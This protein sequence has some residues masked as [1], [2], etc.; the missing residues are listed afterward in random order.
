M[1]TLIFL[2][3]AFAIA[4]VSGWGALGVSEY[5]SFA[6]ADQ[7]D[8]GSYF[9]RNSVAFFGSPESYCSHCLGFGLAYLASGAMGMFFL[10]QRTASGVLLS[11]LIGGGILLFESIL[12]SV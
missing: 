1:R 4:L 9:S 7:A 12:L 10:F 2:A 5:Y 8:I 6:F 11:S 3:S